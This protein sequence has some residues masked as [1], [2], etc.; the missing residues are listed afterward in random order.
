MLT[1]VL[2]LLSAL[3]VTGALKLAFVHSTWSLLFPFLVTLVAVAVLLMRRMSQRLEPLIEETQRHLA[4]GRRELALKSLREGL[5]FGLWHPLVAAQLRAQI[6]ELQYA[7]GDLDQAEAEL[8]QSSRWPWTSRALLGCVYFK[9]HETDKM[10]R[11]F[12]VAVKVGDKEAL[13]WTLYAYCE[14]A[15]GEREAAVKLLER[16]LKKCPGDARLLANLELARE[17]KKLKVAP[18]G[19]RWTRFGLDTEGPVLPKA[20]RGFA[21]KPGF[22]QRSRRK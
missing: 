19:D 8:A 21:V 10:K 20:A 2:A 13:S 12:E 17:G 16:G 14:L 4:G 18:Y 6:G 22:R 7:L 3:A 15:R 5:R 9:K 11:A 1:I